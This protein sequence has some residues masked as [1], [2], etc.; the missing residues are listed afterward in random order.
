LVKLDLAENKPSSGGGQEPA[1]RSQQSIAAVG[2]DS[3]LALLDNIGAM[4][5][6]I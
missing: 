1:F 6:T 2:G 3:I 5:D 4:S